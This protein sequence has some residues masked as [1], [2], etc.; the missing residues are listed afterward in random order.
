[1]A[2][3]AP[4]TDLYQPSHKTPDQLVRAVTPVYGDEAKFSTDDQQIIIRADELIVN[5]ILALLLQLDHPPRVYQLEISN[6][7]GS[8]KVKTYSTESRELSQSLFILTENQ[9]LIIAQQ[10]QT[11]QVNTLRPLWRT[12]NT[13]PVQQE[14]LTL[15]LQASKNYVYI[16]IQLQTLKNGQAAM[17]NSKVTGPLYEWLAV[18]GNKRNADSMSKTHS[19][20]RADISD[21]YIKVNPVD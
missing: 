15:N 13:I 1:M 18:T 16:D 7:P 20:H 19:T 9:P 14:A 5:E 2:G 17:I 3:S 12:V 6:N 21:L 8:R 4:A 10:Q 11:Q